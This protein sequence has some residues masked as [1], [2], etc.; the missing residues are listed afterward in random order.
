MPPAAVVALAAVGL[1][2]A[3]VR[4]AST[5]MEPTLSPGDRL[6]VHTYG[7]GQGAPD[8]GD[9]VVF[10]RDGALLLKRVAAV[11]GETV[12]IEDGVLT[13]DGRPVREPAVDRRLVDGMYFGPVT[14][15]DGTVFLLGDNRRGSVDSREFGPVPVERLTG[16]VLLRW[17]P[18]PGPP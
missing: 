6:L 16:R 3:P 18:R 13:V 15:P 2:V 12:G 9:L 8:R 11:A 4:V 1:L 10:D 5:S 14:V 7:Y 17:W